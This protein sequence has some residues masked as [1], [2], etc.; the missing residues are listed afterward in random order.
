MDAETAEDLRELV[1]YDE[2]TAGGLMTTDYFWI[3]PHRT[4]GATIAKIRE[5]APETE[6]IY[7]LYV[8]DQSEKL[9]GVLSLR[10]LLLSSHDA[11]IHSIMDAA[12]AS[13][14]HAW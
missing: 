2:D 4:V 13:V 10:T 14:G 12:L 9:L 8:T 6:F 3:Y 7:Y 5:I 11:T 1:A